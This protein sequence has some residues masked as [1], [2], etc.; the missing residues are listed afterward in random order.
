MTGATA[1]REVARTALEQVC[2]RGDMDLAPRCYAEDFADH[3]GRLDYH[4]LDGV[5][6]STE[7]YRTLFDD[8]A[9][10]V[11]DQ[12]AEGDRVT[13]RWQLRGT[14]RGR[15]VEL[16]GITIS[17]LEGERIV[18]DWTALDSLE[19]LRGLGLRRTALAVPRLL[20]VLRE[21]RAR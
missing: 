12:I 20:R 15:H 21:A 19:L 8:L 11:L 17:R 18:E 13:S 16:W 6:R 5:R 9:I 2:A 10:E 1:N 4:G 3:V 7:L 14:N